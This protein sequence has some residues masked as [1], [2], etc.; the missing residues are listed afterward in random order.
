L[1][2]HRVV[3]GVDGGGTQTRCCVSDLNRRVLGEGRAGP[4]N[5]RAV[6][7]GEAGANLHKAV[8]AALQEAGCPPADVAAACFGLAGAG[9][10]EDQ[11]VVRS[12]LPDLGGA[13]VRVVPDAHIALAGA[14]AGRPGVIAIAG[15]GSVAFGVDAL[16][17]TARAG[18][19]GWLLGD[20]GSGY[21]IGLQGVR[22]ALGAAD[23]TGPATRI[24]Q[25]LC[26]AWG[27]TRLEQAIGRVYDD[28]AAARRAMADLAPIVMR[29]ASEGDTVAGGILEQAGRELAALVVAVFATLGSAAAASPLFSGIGGVLTACEP[30]RESLRAAV[31]IQVPTAHYLTPQ[32]GPAE[33]AIRMALQM[34]SHP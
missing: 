9:R 2:I 7:R 8:A 32:E 15:T 3:L 20:E 14:L 6:G 26:E 33:G 13:P 22:A 28:P 24:Q 10:P 34:I 27:L 29:A 16:G 25:L 11:Q 21:H 18:G 12:L 19:W 23:G 5:Y 17:R 31:T 4:S 30:L 1:V